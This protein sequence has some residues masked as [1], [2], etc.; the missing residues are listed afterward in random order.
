[1][2]VINALSKLA[3]CQGFQGSP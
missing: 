2:W 1:V 3:A